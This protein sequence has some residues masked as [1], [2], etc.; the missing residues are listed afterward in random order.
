MDIVTA[1]DFVKV[2]LFMLEDTI[3]KFSEAYINLFGDL[4]PKMH[5]ITH[6]AHIM[7]LIGPLIH[8]WGMPFERK[9]KE[10]KQLAINTSCYKNLPWTIAFRSQLRM[11]EVT[12]T[13]QA[14]QIKINLGP[15]LNNSDFE[16]STI[17]SNITSAKTYKFIKIY[18]KILR[19]GMVLL[20]TNDE[21]EGPVMREISKI[22]EI[23]ENIYFLL[24]EI[25]IVYFDAHY[26]AYKVQLTNK[27]VQLIHVDRLPTTCPPCCLIKKGDSHY[28]AT[29]FQI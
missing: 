22:Y 21:N 13:L 12:K 14:M 28:V 15:L 8:F 27:I 25:I 3:R 29:R 16:I 5:L 7:Q 26:H 11:S 19:P 6:F 23:N 20:I 2:D 4:K 18:G 10:L 9:N 17:L 1:V 24:N